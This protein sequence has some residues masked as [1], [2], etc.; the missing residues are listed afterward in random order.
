M[1]CGPPVT[2]GPRSLGPGRVP[3]EESMQVIWLA[4]SLQASR[5]HMAWLADGDR[6]PDAPPG[7]A[8]LSLDASMPRCVVAHSCPVRRRAGGR[9]GYRLVH[10][11]EEGTPR[12][13]LRGGRFFVQDFGLRPEQWRRRKRPNS[14]ETHD[15][16]NARH[17]PLS[18]PSSPE[19]PG[20]RDRHHPRQGVGDRHLRPG[21]P[22]SGSSCSR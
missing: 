19:Q 22:W 8:P 13:N 9:A 3:P 2:N 16:R 6:S 21:G 12:Q 18:G 15:C 11:C 20:R 7:W 14:R 5:R 4:A 17:E 10:G 1:L